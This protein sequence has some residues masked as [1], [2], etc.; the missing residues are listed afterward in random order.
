M[1]TTTYVVFDNGGDHLLQFVVPL[2]ELSHSLSHLVNLGQQRLCL[3]V[4]LLYG[5]LVREGGREGGRERGG[6]GGREGGREGHVCLVKY[7]EYSK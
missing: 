7:C 3:A 2:C 5:G 4:D 6:G 1:C